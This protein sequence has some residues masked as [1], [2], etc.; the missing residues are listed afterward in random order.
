MTNVDLRCRE[1][2]EKFDLLFAERPQLTH[3]KLADA[4]RCIIHLRDALIEQHRTGTSTKRDDD[5]LSSVNSLL[6]LASSAEFPLVGVRW[7]R[8]VALRDALRD[9]TDQRGGAVAAPR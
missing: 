6:S 2:C 1:A 8:I 9:L 4:V 3:E 5:R 7:E